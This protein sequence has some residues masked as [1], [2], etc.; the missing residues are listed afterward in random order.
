[1][2]YRLFRKQT[3]MTPLEYRHRPR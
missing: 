2:F 1:Y 3:G